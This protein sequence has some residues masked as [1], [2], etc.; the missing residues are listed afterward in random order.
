[1]IRGAAPA[2][3]SRE[4]TPSSPEH[5]FMRLS[6]GRYLTFIPLSSRSSVLI[7]GYG[8]DIGIQRGKRRRWFVHRGLRNPEIA[9]MV[10]HLN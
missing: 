4:S 2:E 5:Q 9:A 1:M 6:V 7:C 8:E 3:K 10:V